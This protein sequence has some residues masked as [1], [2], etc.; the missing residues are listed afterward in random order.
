MRCRARPIVTL[1]R[2]SR[3]AEVT[4]AELA[5]QAGSTPKRSPVSADTTAV[6][7]STAPS[8]PMVWRRGTLAGAADTKR[9][10]PRVGEQHTHGTAHER[11]ERALDE[12]L[13]HEPESAIERALVDI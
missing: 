1:R 6:N 3:S 13:P 8:M 4:R 9:T 12:H 7:A 5:R 2:P 11:Q 10:N